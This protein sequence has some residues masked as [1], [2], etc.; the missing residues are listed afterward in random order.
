MLDSTMNHISDAANQ[1]DE[2][3]F[4]KDIDVKAVDDVAPAHERKFQD[5]DHF[6]GTPYAK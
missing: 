1:V 5:I 2:D 4:L 6:F 3:G